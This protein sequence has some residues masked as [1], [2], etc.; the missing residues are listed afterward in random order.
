M[1]KIAGDAGLIRRMLTDLDRLKQWFETWNVTI[2]ERRRCLRLLH[3]ALV[4]S[5]Q[6]EAPAKV[7]YELLSSYTTEADAAT[8]KDDARQCIRSAIFDPGAFVFDHLLSLRPVQSLKG[9]KIYD[10]LLIFVNGSLKD[11]LQFYESN[12]SFV[13]DDLG[14]GKNL[15]NETPHTANVHKMRV[16]T[17]MGI[18]ET[19]NEIPLPELSQE[20]HLGN[21]EEL[22]E[23]IIKCIQ[24]KAIKA[25]I[26]QM[27]EKLIIGGVKNRSFGKP[28][29]ESLKSKLDVWSTSLRHVKRYMD[30]VGGIES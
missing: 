4:K 15:S 7:M 13:D 5:Q 24:A 23:F 3:D 10:L 6:I 25:K 17:L 30:T 16:L 26:D 11:Y 21:G 22:E 29:W 9:E 20:L 1:L 8:A 14:G 27:N 28:Q 2:D 19:K 18:G 12:K